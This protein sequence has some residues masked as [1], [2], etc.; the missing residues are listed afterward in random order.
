MRDLV[1]KTDILIVGAGLSGLALADQL[2]Q[3]GRDVTVLEARPDVGGRIL[4][5]QYADKGF[6]LG[7]SWFWHG[8]PKI[9]ALI[10]RFKLTQ[11]DQFAQG[12]VL[13]EDSEGPVQRGAGFASMEG[14]LRLDGGIGQL[15][16]ALVD[17]VGRNRVFCDTL[18]QSVTFGEKITV[19]CDTP[20]GTKQITANKIVLALPP[21]VAVS[22]IE[23]DPPLPQASLNA[24]LDVPTWMAGHAK[25]LAIYDD[26]IW[27][28]AG[29]SGD[30]MSRRGPM[31]EIHDAS[32]AEGGPYALFG[33]VGFPPPIRAQHRDEVLDAARDQLQ[34]LFGPAAGDPKELIMQDWAFDEFTST[35]ADHVPLQG[36]PAYGR[37]AALGPLCDGR[38]FFG[39]T[40]MATTNGGLMEGALEAAEDVA[41]LI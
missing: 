25:I 39:S 38:L 23:F 29:L 34:R 35:D 12:D 27:R 5:V 16:N 19:T 36:H 13:A 32:S 10:E 22:S 21:R 40:E 1:K 11:F 33:F 41:S 15:T 37:P 17:A 20:I 26:P 8:Q 18:V 14:S 31:V 7:P 24:A 4:S 3:G 28:D 9:A 6:D 2:V 30:A